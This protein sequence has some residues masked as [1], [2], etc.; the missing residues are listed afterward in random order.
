LAFCVS[1]VTSIGLLF[2]VSRLASRFAAS[3]DS[4]TTSISA[5]STPRW[6]MLAVIFSLSTDRISAKSYYEQDQTPA[7]REFHS[8]QG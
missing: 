2:L 1:G 8:P 7:I 3:L 5:L 4:L 6:I